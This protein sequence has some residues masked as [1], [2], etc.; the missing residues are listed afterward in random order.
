[1]SEREPQER[2]LR[3]EVRA[4]I[5][6][7]GSAAAHTK[8]VSNPLAAASLKEMIDGGF[9]LFFVTAIDIS[10]KENPGSTGQMLRR[11]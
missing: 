9:V 6:K 11:R 3:K 1:M 4:H 5:W 8:A 2:S 10:L 7:E